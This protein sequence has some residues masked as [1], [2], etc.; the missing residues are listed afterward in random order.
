MLTK[1][2]GHSTLLC[3]LQGIGSFEDGT[4]LSSRV[5]C[6]G[7]LLPCRVRYY[8]T[9][10]VCDFTGPTWQTVLTDPKVL[11]LPLPGRLLR[12]E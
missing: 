8:P 10:I 4:P 9:L 3:T 12:R 1:Y 2:S 11:S 6:N 7:K 5:N